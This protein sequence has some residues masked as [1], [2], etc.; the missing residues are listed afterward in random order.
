MKIALLDAATLANADLTP[1]SCMGELKIYQHTDPEQII[2]HCENAEVLISN[3][4]ILNE[5]T[6]SKLPKLKL[7]CVAATGTNN[8]DLK[9]ARKF[10]IRVCNV[11]NYSTPSVVQHTFTLLGNL[12]TNSHRYIDDCKAGL[13]QNSAMFCRLDYPITEIA[14]KNFVIIGYGSLGKAVAKVAQA[15]GANVIIAE[16]ENAEEIRSG[17]TSFKE[18]LKKADVLSIHCPLSD[19][20]KY[21]LN[22]NTLS[23]L[24]PSCFIINTARGGIVDEEALVEAL[25]NNTLAGAGFDVLSIEPAHPNNPLINYQGNNLILTPHIAWASKES[26]ERLIQ[27]IANNIA[28]FISKTPSNVVI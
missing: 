6:L 4:V 17:R 20:T 18:A 25:Q 3:K 1:I 24:K 27:E 16:R 15:F 14:N 10:N 9:A 2:K 23:L 5:L 8:I 19:S 28:N 7:I 11:A 26:I 21:L 13:W 22:V 12:M